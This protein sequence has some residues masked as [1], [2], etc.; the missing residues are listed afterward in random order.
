MQLSIN[1]SLPNQSI[2]VST[3]NE[4]I[5]IVDQLIPTCCNAGP[6]KYR[7]VASVKER[8]IK[9]LTFD[10]ALPQLIQLSKNGKSIASPSVIDSHTP[11]RVLPQPIPST[12]IQQAASEKDTTHKARKKQGYVIYQDGQ[13]IY[14]CPNCRKTFKNSGDVSR[15]RRLIHKNPAGIQ[16]APLPERSFYTCESCSQTFS[17]KELFISHTHIHPQKKPHQCLYCAKTYKYVSSL[18]THKRLFHT[19]S[20]ANTSSNP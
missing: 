6:I 3:S 2:V 10:E 19:E 9:R 11:S 1:N 15:H 5:S 20:V 8:R 18:N 16:P 13:K 14:A 4:P 7:S 12:S 17:T